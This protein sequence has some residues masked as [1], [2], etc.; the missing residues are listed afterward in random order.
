MLKLFLGIELKNDLQLKDK[1]TDLAQNNIDLQLLSKE[2]NV[3]NSIDYQIGKNL[4]TSKLLL[5][6]L[7]KSRAL[8]SLGANVNFGYNAFG[9]Q[10]QFFSQNQNGS[11]FP[12]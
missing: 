3:T 7:E 8:P 9:D 10:F 5:L 4:E 12:M 6:K 11:T 2:F 1:L